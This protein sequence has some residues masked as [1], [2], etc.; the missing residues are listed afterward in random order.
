M[1]FDILATAFCFTF[2]R[3]TRGKNLETAAGTEWEVLE[4][5]RPM[6]DASSGEKGEHVAPVTARAGSV[7]VDEAHGKVLE[8]TEAHDTFGS[9]LKHRR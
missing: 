1:G 9:D 3:E 6:D 4:K 2:V 7:V 5:E 8:V